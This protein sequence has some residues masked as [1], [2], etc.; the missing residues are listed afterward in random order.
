[1]PFADERERIACIEQGLHSQFWLDYLLPMLMD[2]GR[3]ALKALVRKT[4]DDDTNRGKYAALQ[5]VIETPQREIDAYKVET[6]NRARIEQAEQ[7]TTMRAELGYRSPFSAPVEPGALTED[8]SD[9]MRA[10]TAQE[11]S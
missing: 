7:S 2:R 9:D 1:V 4:D 10:T 6:K 3:N 11:Q 5:D 8:E